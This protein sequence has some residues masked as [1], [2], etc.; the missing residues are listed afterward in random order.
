MKFIKQTLG[1]RVLHYI[2]PVS[3][4]TTTLNGARISYEGV[5]LLSPTL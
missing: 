3:I 2:Y 4:L 5:I 1:F